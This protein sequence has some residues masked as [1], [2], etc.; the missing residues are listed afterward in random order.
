MELHFKAPYIS[1]DEF[2]PVVIPDFTVL[3]GV[4]GSGKSHLMEAIEKKHATILGMEQAHTVLFN[5]ET[6]RLENESAFKAEQL[7]NEREAAW[8]YLM[9]P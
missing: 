7:A 4:N 1:I 8:Q 3:T 9:C 5:Y 2:N 6:F